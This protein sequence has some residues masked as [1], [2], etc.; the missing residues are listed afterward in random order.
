[1]WEWEELECFDVAA[2]LHSKPRFP[3]F[4]LYL[5]TEIPRGIQHQLGDTS[6]GHGYD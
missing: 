2:R 1:M 4:I 5:S 3:V 6:L